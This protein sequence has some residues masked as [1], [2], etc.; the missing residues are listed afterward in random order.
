MHVEFHVLF[1][2]TYIHPVNLF[3]MCGSVKIH[4]LDE[5]KVENHGC[6]EVSDYYE[7][8]YHPQPAIF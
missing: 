7:E 6:S 8:N 1:F 2:A 5:G 3:L 4:F